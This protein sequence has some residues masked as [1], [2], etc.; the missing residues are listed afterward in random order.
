MISEKAACPN[1]QYYLLYYMRQWILYIKDFRGSLHMIMVMNE[2][3]TV[4]PTI[5]FLNAVLELSVL[6]IYEL[7]ITT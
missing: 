5:N 1:G 3:L 4:F 6:Y 7:H 2:V